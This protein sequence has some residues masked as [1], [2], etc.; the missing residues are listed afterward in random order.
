MQKSGCLFVEKS[1]KW[2]PNFSLLVWYYLLFNKKWAH[3]KHGRTTQGKDKVRCHCA[4]GKKLTWV[5]LTCIACLWVALA[6]GSLVVRPLYSSFPPHPSFRVAT[7]GAK[8]KRG[9]KVA[10]GG[11]SA[12]RMRK[13]AQ[14][15]K[16]R[17]PNYRAI[18]RSEQ[19]Q[20]VP[21]E[22][23]REKGKAAHL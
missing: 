13:S 5:C 15:P 8:W 11:N 16:P 23:S 14:D 10:V 3:K 9:G 17:P 6:R 4:E 2:H 1:C 19:Q 18:M 21:A 22:W 20:R 12:S 7:A